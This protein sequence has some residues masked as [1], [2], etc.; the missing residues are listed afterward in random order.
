MIAVA[1]RAP[2]RLVVVTRK[3]PMHS[4][5]LK[6]MPTE[7]IEYPL[8]LVLSVWASVSGLA[9]L[10]GVS[11]PVS[12]TETLPEGLQVAWGAALTLSGATIG[13]GLALRKYGTLVARGLSLLAPA[14]L[15][16]GISIF[17]WGGIDRA[18]PAGPLLFSI[19]ILCWLRAWW[20]NKREEILRYL[21]KGGGS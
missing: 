5:L 2:R 1:R 12:I 19:A 4:L 3:D 13:I 18:V 9:L 21:A 7:V 10:A 15:V 16:Y 20:L 6:R 8:E 17:I 14:A 11:D